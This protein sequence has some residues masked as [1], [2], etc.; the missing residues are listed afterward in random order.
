MLEQWG[1]MRFVWATEWTDST[2]GIPGECTSA[3][4]AEK[5]L[6]TTDA[7]TVVWGTVGQVGDTYLCS[8][9]RISREA[10]AD[11]RYEGGPLAPGA[12]SANNRDTETAADKRY[13][14]FQEEI[15]GGVSDV[16]KYAI[17]NLAMKLVRR[18]D[19]VIQKPD[20]SVSQRAV[21]PSH[22]APAST[23]A[24]GMGW[25][26][27]Q[28][29]DDNVKLFLDGEPVGKGNK[30][31]EVPVGVHRITAKTQEESES[32]LVEVYKNDISSISF[33]I[34]GVVS[35]SRFFMA[36][37]ASIMLGEGVEYGPSHMVGIEIQGK[38]LVAINYYWGVVSHNAI[39]GGGFQYLYTFNVH[40]IFLA[41]LGAGAGFWFE[42]YIYMYWDPA[43]DDYIDGLSQEMYFGGPKARLEVGYKKVYFTIVDATLLLGTN[44][45]KA[46]LN[47]GISFRL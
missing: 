42:E 47:C 11:D 35:R 44:T 3:D 32:Q 4:A 23:Q 39:L 37:D 36:F 30:E 26:R 10:P 24:A 6:E 20:M 45:P 34:G 1:D 38:H 25:I 16:L 27:I 43:Y 46:M 17:H 13:E 40:D 9:Y 22:S 15:R 8:V 33:D 5:V 18:P 2:H 41:R 31:L 14:I 7:Q 29:K 12:F 19:K 21:V 28:V